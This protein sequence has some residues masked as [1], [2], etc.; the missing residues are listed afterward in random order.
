[1]GISPE[2]H[3]EEVERWRRG[4]LEKLTGPEGWL[5]LVGLWWL[6]EGDNR[7]GSDPANDAVLP[8]DTS[9][10]AVGVV[11][12][13]DGIAT[14][15]PAPGWPVRH[16]GR[17]VTDSLRLDDDSGGDP[18]I[19][20]LGTLSF[21]VVRRGGVLAVRVRD[22]DAAARSEFRG[23]EHYLVD[24]RWRIEARFEPYDPPRATLVPT[25]LGTEETYPT[26]GSVEFEVNGASHRL[27]VFLEPPGKD[28]FVVFGDHTNR[29]ETF[30]GGRYL[31]ARPPGEDGAVVLDFN[32]AYNPPC[33]FT[34]HATCPLPLPQNRLPIRIEAG[35]KRYEGGPA[36]D[37]TLSPHR[38]MF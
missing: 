4:R 30:G 27:D 21:F 1:M 34:A 3:A 37:S 13:R 36:K 16:R 7:V 2:Q 18:T 28:L 26:P 17:P 32:K 5:S 19:L 33:V 11:R 35:E 20:S 29:D 8:E 14:F 22:A 9:P 24:I 10:P 38:P 23:I 25:V 6:S 15:I 31:Y 12:V